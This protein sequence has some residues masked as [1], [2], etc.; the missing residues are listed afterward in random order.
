MKRLFDDAYAIFFS[1]FPFESIILC[2][3]H[4]FELPPQIKA[5]HMSAYNACFYKVDKRTQA[6]NERIQNYLTVPLKGYVHNYCICP[7][8][9]TVCLI[10]KK[11]KKKLRKA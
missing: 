11:T 2:C 3:G 9:H 5:I 6:V 10:K 4:S 7:N 8:Y 1:G